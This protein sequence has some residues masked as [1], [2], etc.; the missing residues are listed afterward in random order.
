MITIGKIKSRK[1]IVDGIEFDRKNH[2]KYIHGLSKTRLYR[3]WADMLQR[4]NNKKSTNYKYYGAKGIRVCEEWYEFINFYEWA[5][6]NG[7][8]DNL[9]IDRVD[10]KGNYNPN[11]CRWVSREVQDNNRRDNVKQYVEGELLTLAQIAKKYN[12]PYSTITNRYRLGDRGSELI[13]EQAQGVKRHGKQRR[14][15]FTK[16][17]KQ[18]VGEIKWL[19]QETQLT[20]KQIG[21]V[22]E[23]TQPMVGNIKRGDMHKDIAPKKPEWWDKY[24]EDK[25]KKNCC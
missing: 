5:C 24:G 15:Q 3:R 19:S 4:C 10:P 14:N 12:I 21:D 13:S 8:D 7:Y 2:W 17:N 1:T 6:E 22:F 25:F 23:V 16:L 18:I 9:S 11:N 20:Q